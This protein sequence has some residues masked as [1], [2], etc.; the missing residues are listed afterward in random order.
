VYQRRREASVMLLSE[1]V[2]SSCL[3]C[4]K[5]TY[6][7]ACFLYLDSMTCFDYDTYQGCSTLFIDAPL[8]QS[9]EPSVR[10]SDASLGACAGTGPF[11]FFALFAVENLA[12]CRGG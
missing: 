11:A 10:K 3:L 6:L 1:L 12:D 4:V 7:I 5:N 2:R 8:G 9:I